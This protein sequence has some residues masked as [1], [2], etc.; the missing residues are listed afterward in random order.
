MTATYDVQKAEGLALVEFPSY[1]QLAIVPDV[2]QFAAAGQQVGR[3]KGCRPPEN[4]DFRRVHDA[5]QKLKNT[6]ETVTY[7]DLLEAWR[8]VLCN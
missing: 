8:E 6:G 3:E 4:K 5:I 1:R 2:Q 7:E